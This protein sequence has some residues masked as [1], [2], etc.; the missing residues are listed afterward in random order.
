VAGGQPVSQ[1]VD[2]R[3]LLVHAAAV[4]DLIRRRWPIRALSGAIAVIVGR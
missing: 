3:G 1:P 2:E 4:P